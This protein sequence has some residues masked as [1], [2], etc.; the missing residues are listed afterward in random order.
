MLTQDYKLR[1]YQED[2]IQ[3]IFKS[4]SAGNRRVMLQLPTGAG[5]TI[6]FSAISRLFLEQGLGVLVLAHRKELITQAHSK[7]E[8][9][10]GLSAGFIKARMP[11]D[12]DFLVQVASVQTLTRRQR[13][14]EAG[15]VICDEAHHSVSKSY[16]RIFEAYPDAYILGVTATPMRTDG[17]GLKNH[18]DD[19]IVGVSV[20]WLVGRGYLCP[21]RLYAAPVKVDTRG[22][23]ITAGEFNQRDLAEAVDTSLVA[24]DVID[25]WKKYAFNKQTV[26]FNVSVEYS[27]KLTKAFRAEGIKAE[28]LDGETPDVERDAIIGRFRNRE[29]TVLS[30]CGIVTEGFD[31]PGIECI[32]CVRP[33]RSLIL[34]LQMIGRSLRPSEGKDYAILIDHSEN[35]QC[36]GLPDDDREW[37]LAPVSLKPSRFTKVCPK[38]CHVFSPLPHE[39]SKPWRVDKD[40]D[41][42]LRNFH[43]CT[44]PACLHEFE[45]PL[46]EAE[47]EI[48]VQGAPFI[49]KRVEVVE[50]DLDV[51]PWAVELIEELLEKQQKGNYKKGWVYYKL[52]EHSLAKEFSLGSWRCFAEKLGYKKGWGW[53]QW[54]RIQEG[55]VIKESSLERV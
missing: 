40:V 21:F 47:Q 13:Y 30:N 32:Q 16:T 7:L 31:V 19:L 51:Q 36:L 22:V 2:L 18:Y 29:T 9:I 53:Y 37:S 25:A 50:I 46:G 4:W 3:G 38:C 44:C 24:G 43:R 8:A 42:K 35:W 23:K 15:L 20:D 54:Q 52:I 14:P 39:L 1:D 45:F 5:K 28:H 41:G 55:N 48:G 33:T 6:L 49:D 27:R 10:S 12:W 26:V 11:V 17:Q 34:W